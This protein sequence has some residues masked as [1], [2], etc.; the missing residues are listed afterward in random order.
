MIV[1]YKQ[2]Q[3]Q[4]QLDQDYLLFRMESAACSKILVRYQTWP[5]D[6]Q[7]IDNLKMKQGHFDTTTTTTKFSD[8]FK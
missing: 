2:Q 1:S 6:N 7:P 4:Q 8:Y 3:K 5:E